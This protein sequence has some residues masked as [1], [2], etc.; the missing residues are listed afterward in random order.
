MECGL[1]MNLSATSLNLL[2]VLHNTYHLIMQNNCILLL[3][4][5]SVCESLNNPSNGEVVINDSTRVVGSIA[6][7]NCDGGFFLSGSIEREC[8]DNG[9]WSGDEPRCIERMYQWNA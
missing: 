3:I 7:Y 6:T 5:L 1:E 4:Y 8:Q 9:T 2:E